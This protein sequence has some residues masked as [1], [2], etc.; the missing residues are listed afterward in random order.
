MELASVLAGE[1]FSDHPK[2]VCPVI[3]GLLRA[4]N[5]AVDGDHR[6]A[7]LPY[8]ARIVGTREM[9]E[10]RIARAER[11]C[12]WVANLAA[13]SPPWQWRRRRL[14]RRPAAITGSGAACGA[15]VVRMLPRPAHKSQADLLALVD[16]LI[17]MGERPPAL[18]P[19][20]VPEPAVA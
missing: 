7:L 3:G 9:G 12:E 15:W 2:S 14:G 10:V 8:A 1:R 6:Q 17:A 18:V 4:Y 19:S 5:D 20:A 16:E 13:Q 11:C